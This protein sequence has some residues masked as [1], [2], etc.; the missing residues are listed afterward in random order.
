MTQLAL[1]KKPNVQRVYCIIMKSKNQCAIKT[2]TSSHDKLYNC[3]IGCRW[4][5]TIEKYF[6]YDS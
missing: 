3:K 6:D 4:I 1:E 5:Q 2:T